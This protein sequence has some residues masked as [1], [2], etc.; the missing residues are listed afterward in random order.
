MVEGESGTVRGVSFGS[1]E[2][3]I[4]VAGGYA[5]LEDKVSMSFRYAL[6]VVYNDEGTIPASAERGGD[7]DIA[8]TGIA[9]VPEEFME[10]VLD[11]EDTTRTAACTFCP[12]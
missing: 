7:V 5:R 3:G 8:G 4:E 12:E 10:G 1:G 6:T 9:G 11:V 2:Y